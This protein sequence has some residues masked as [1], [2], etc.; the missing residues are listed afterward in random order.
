MIVALSIA[1]IAIALLPAVTFL[2][3]LPLFLFSGR[4]DD[5]DGESTPRVSVLIPARDEARVIANSVQAALASQRVDVEV[6]VLDDGSSDA[7]GE[8]VRRFADTDSRVRYLRGAALP[9]GWNGKQHACKQLAAAAT[10][11]RIV[12]I[13]ADVR[14]QPDALIQLIRYQTRGQVAL[15][16]AFP[17]QE[18]GTILE[19]WI[20]PMMHVILLGFLP[21]RRMRASS[22]PAYAAGCGQLFLTSKRDYDRAGTHEAIRSSR[23]DGVKL[24]RAYRQAGLMTDLV[25]G[26]DLARCRMYDSAGAV[27]RGVMK[28]AVEGIANPKLILPFSLLLL[29][30]S[31]LPIVTLVWS[32]VV[33][34]VPGIVLSAVGVILGHL[35][36]AIAAVRFRQPISGVL[37][38]SLATLVFVALQW[39]ALALH[40]LGRQVAWRGRKESSFV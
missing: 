14:L 35:P 10:C 32:V 37:C 16:S 4:G 24:P 2:N 30:G 40:L 25:D 12:F 5:C 39:A 38:H 3:N 11:D 26:T 1:G 34:S 20:I 6:I 13:D 7:T 8:I 17:Q 19:K 31:V 36:R 27:I 18:T 9:A 15:L 21:L 28:N 22:H 29:G 23:H 33:H